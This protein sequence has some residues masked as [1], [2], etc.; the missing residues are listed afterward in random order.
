MLQRLS[1]TRPTSRLMF[2]GVPVQEETPRTGRY[3]SGGNPIN[4]TG[5]LSSISMPGD[6]GGDV[7]V[8]RIQLSDSSGSSE[9]GSPKAVESELSCHPLLLPYA[10]LCVLL[11]SALRFPI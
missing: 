10:P 2:A 9:E 7:P 6:A 1:V 4:L 5:D 3:G 11:D 8:R